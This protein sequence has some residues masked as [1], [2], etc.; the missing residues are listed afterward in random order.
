MR[1]PFIIAALLVSAPALAQDPQPV[2]PAPPDPELLEFLG[3][4]G[5]ENPELIQFI[6]T[7]EAQQALKDAEK[8]EAKEDHDE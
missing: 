1:P 2:T 7:H 3:E 6:S 5:G 8:E 4:I